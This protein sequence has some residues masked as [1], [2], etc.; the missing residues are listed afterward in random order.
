MR[1]IRTAPP[2]DAVKPEVKAE[3]VRRRYTTTLREAIVLGDIVSAK[4]KLEEAKTDLDSE[5]QQQD[6]SSVT[7]TMIS[8]L[9]KELLLLL[10]LPVWKE[11]I[12]FLRASWTSHYRQRF[13]GMGDVGSSSG[14]FVTPRMHAYQ[15]QA[16]EFDKNLRIEKGPSVGDDETMASERRPPAVIVLCTVLAIA[17]IVAGATCK[18]RE[19]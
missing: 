2:P 10:S 14:L 7:W 4:R 19:Y 9:K 17:T 16:Q 6:P 3:L 1:R 11:F 18:N 5:Q 8:N 12:S 15:E 13:A